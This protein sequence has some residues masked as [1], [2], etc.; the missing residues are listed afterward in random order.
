M[1]H[2]DLDRTDGGDGQRRPLMWS[3]GGIYA[4]W[5]ILGA[6][7][8]AAVGQLL[9]MAVPGDFEYGMAIGLGAGIA[10]GAAFGSR[11]ADENDRR[12]ARQAEER[13]R[14]KE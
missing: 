8:G 4:L 2:G 12:I 3:R 9:G 5:M 14:A 13:G 10:L 7:L 1:T 11:R 6:V